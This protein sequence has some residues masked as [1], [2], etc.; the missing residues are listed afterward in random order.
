MDTGTHVIIGLILDALHLGQTVAE[1]R[2]DTGTPGYRC[3]PNPR[4]NKHFF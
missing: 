2:I 3:F 4:Y 1:V